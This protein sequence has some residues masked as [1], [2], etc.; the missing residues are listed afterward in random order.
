MG[1]R[2][3]L[4]LRGENIIDVN[5]QRSEILAALKHQK[6]QGKFKSQQI[7]GDGLASGRIAQILADTTI[8][9]TQKILTF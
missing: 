4:R 9:S 1:T 2:Q 6:L 7:Y 8:T 3:D 5:E